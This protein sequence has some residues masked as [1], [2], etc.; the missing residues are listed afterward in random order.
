[1][2]SGGVQDHRHA[3]RSLQ[4]LWANPNVHFETGD[5]LGTN[6]EHLYDLNVEFRFKDTFRKETVPATR[7]RKSSGG[8]TSYLKRPVPRY[9]WSHAI[10]ERDLVNI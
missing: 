1:M 7:E 6:E 10:D 4:E 2:M 5:K 8:S 9:S 3:Q